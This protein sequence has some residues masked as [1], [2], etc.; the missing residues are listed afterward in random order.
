[1]RVADTRTVPA[2]AKLERRARD[3]ADLAAVGTGERVEVA[4]IE[5][6]EAEPS[7][8][9][10]AWLIKT[11]RLFCLDGGVARRYGPN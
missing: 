6:N 3:D 9:Q 10:A 4:L 5:P 8:E 1:L 2:T 11:A 7:A